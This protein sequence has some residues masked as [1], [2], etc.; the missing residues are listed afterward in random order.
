MLT[1]N[2]GWASTRP[3]L[4][5]RD[6]YATNRVD[7]LWN[8]RQDRLY[9]PFGLNAFVIRWP[10][11]Y[12][13]TSSKNLPSIHAARYLESAYSL[14][15]KAGRHDLLRQK[16]T[17]HIKIRV[18]GVEIWLRD[19]APLHGANIAFEGGWQFCDLVE[20]LNRLVFFWPGSAPGPN[21]YGRRHF[22]RYRAEGPL[23]IR[24]PTADLLSENSQV[25]PL[26]C[27]FNSGS[28]RYSAG[29]PSP[30]GPQTFVSGV[31][32]PRTAPKVVELTFPVGIRLPA[33]TEHSFSPDGPWKLLFPAMP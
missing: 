29:L 6:F 5:P 3:E 9:M 21:D 17:T 33:R 31:Q 2:S 22:E 4:N 15:T 19:Q 28:P 23:I 14:L 30:R 11:A 18:N 16:R 20:A 12:H 32:F 26:F 27:A 25:A 10:Y 7:K 1:P 8:F 13:L 24:V